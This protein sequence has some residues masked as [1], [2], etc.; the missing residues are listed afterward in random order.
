M[1]QKTKKLLLFLGA[2]FVAVIFLSSYL[3]FQNNSL[4]TSSTTTV[5]SVATFPVFGSSTATVTGY[6][7]NANITVN[8]VYGGADANV[9]KTLSELET[10][11]SINNYIGS[12]GSY[13]VFLSTINAYYLQ[14]QLQNAVNSSNAVVVSATTYIM[15][16]SNVT[17][18]ANNYPVRVYLSDRNLSV[19][20]TRLECIG[21]IINVSLR[22][23]VTSN[24]ILYGNLGVSPK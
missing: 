15:L 12:N 4:A 1:N 11:G 5:A 10:N 20:T 2:V 14:Q 24:G 17:L 3:S 8:S 9:M 16:P 22:A 21:S 13:E 7:A 23:L 18:Y 19:G 6:G